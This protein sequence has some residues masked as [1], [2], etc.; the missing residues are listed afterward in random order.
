MGARGV[1]KCTHLLVFKHTSSSTPM[2][3]V[4][5]KI[6][7]ECRKLISES[8]NVELYFIKRSANMAAHELAQV[9]HM[10]PDRSFDWSSVPVRV[11]TCILNDLSE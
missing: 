11:K 6:I 1:V 4:L 3:S 9:S 7:Q 8:N 10:Y 2:R 5:G